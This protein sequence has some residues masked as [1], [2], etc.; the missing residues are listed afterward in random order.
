MKNIIKY[1]TFVAIFA[2]FSA[3]N[4]DPIDGLT[5]KYPAP[6]DYTLTTLASQNVVKQDG[7][8]R[9]I[10]L[11]FTSADAA[12]NVDF[13]VNAHFLKENGYTLAPATDAKNGNYTAATFTKTG[14]GAQSVT[15]GVIHVKLLGESD[16]TVSGTLQLADKSFVKIAFA[17]AIVF[18]ADPP[19]V[20]YSIAVQKP[21]A[22]TMDGQNYTTVEGSQLNKITV[23][24]DGAVVAYFEIVTEENPT[25]LAGTYAVKAVN[26]LERAIVQGQFMNLLWLGMFDMP[27]ESGSYLLDGDKLFVRSGNVTITDDNGTLSF[28]SSDLAIQ[29]ISTQMAFGTL[30]TP[31][32]I[33]YPEATREVSALPMPNL[34][35]A[36][37]TDLAA[38]SGG[39][40]TGYTVTLKFGEAGLTATP[41]MFGG[42]DIG[43]TGKYVSIDFKRDAGTLPAGTYAIKADAEAAAGDAIAGYYLDLGGFGFNSGCLW[44][45]VVDGVSTETFITG[46]TV[47]VAESGGVYTVTVNATTAGGEPVIAVYTGAITLQ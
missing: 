7:G 45:S 9:K 32:S 15:A 22:F 27:I 1:L 46:G 25:T 20:T 35:A 26:S 4:E 29:D 41:N 39:A 8:I 31:A 24:S 12:L 40:L 5:G 14:A 33:N 2:A 36:S 19:A 17:G 11:Q 10:T 16:Y 42:L 3:C 30:P 6:T 18:E 38:V 28:A 13:V 37:V 23:K 44:V 34:L 21:Y 43:G 47:V